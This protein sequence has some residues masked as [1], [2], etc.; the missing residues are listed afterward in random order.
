[1]S[2]YTFLITALYLFSCNNL[3]EDPNAPEKPVWVEKSQ[4]D[5]PVE[6][7]IDSD[8]AIGDGIVLMWHANSESDLAGYN[9]YRGQQAGESNIEYANIASI[10][11]FKDFEF[12]TLYFDENTS[13][14]VDYYY[15]LTAENLFGKESSPSDTI[16]Y[17]LLKA[18]TPL[19]PTGTIADSI[20]IFRWIDNVVNFEY[21]NEFVI[22]VELSNENYMEPIWVCR[23]Y[24]QWFGYEN[25][26][27]ISF[28]FFPAM[29]TWTD[30]TTSEPNL[31]PNAPSNV[32]SCYGITTVMGNGTYR[33]KVKAISQVNN[34]TGIDE[35]S[36]ETGWSY[37]NITY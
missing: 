16:S 30:N 22:R 10:D 4:P 6:L 11:I 19:S 28:L 31:H 20:P 29:G 32:I 7:G 18:P 15:Y 26:I 24:N 14:Y 23:F 3:N 27:P 33:W 35:S 13:S 17:K 37:F 12:D 21:S 5:Q 36:S 25:S 8:N 2:K 9:I 1:L 34:E